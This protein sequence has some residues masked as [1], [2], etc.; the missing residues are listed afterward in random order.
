MSKST[1]IAL[2]RSGDYS[3]EMHYCGAKHDGYVLNCGDSIVLAVQI[4]ITDV[5]VIVG[6]LF[7]VLFVFDV[8]VLIRRHLDFTLGQFCLSFRVPPTSAAQDV[9]CGTT[10][11]TTS[12]SPTGRPTISAVL[13]ST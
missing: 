4:V 7:A 2:T 6:Q 8:P 1:K 9:G 11:T 3:D 13:S 12:A 5:I 10:M